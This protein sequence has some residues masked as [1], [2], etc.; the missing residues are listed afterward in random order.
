MAEKY[1]KA[2]HL[3]VG[4]EGSLVSS[5]HGLIRPGESVDGKLTEFELAQAQRNGTVIS[6]DAPARPKQGTE[7]QPPRGGKWN[8]DPE[9]LKSLDIKQL[10]LRVQEIDPTAPQ[11]ETVEEA[12]AQLSQN[13]RRSA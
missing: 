6:R 7:A 9:K 11:F 13:F 2:E 12:I 4:P 10:N 3:V 5:M 8:Q 1:M